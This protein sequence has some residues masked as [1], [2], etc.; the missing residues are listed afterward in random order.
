MYMQSIFYCT[1]E[2][3]KIYSWIFLKP[4]GYQLLALLHELEKQVFYLVATTK[5]NDIL[6]PRRSVGVTYKKDDANDDVDNDNDKYSYKT[7]VKL[8]SLQF[9][10]CTNNY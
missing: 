8:R 1:T 5:I 10:L 6:W 9:V 3:S 4:N 2:K 7:P